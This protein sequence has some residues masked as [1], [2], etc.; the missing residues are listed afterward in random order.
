MSWLVIEMG[1]VSYR[2]LEKTQ[3]ENLR[4]DLLE[5]RHFGTLTGWSERGLK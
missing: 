2:A 5:C 4:A 1:F 3:R